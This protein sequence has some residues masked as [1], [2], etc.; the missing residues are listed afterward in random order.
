MSDILIL[1]LGVLAASNALVLVGLALWHRRNYAPVSL[2]V[3]S[4][5]KGAEYRVIDGPHHLASGSVILGN[6]YGFAHQ[7]AIKTEGA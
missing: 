7:N 1:V 6:T 3:V 2:E 5:E 4:G